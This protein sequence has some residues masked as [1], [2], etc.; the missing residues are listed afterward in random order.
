MFVSLSTMYGLPY[1]VKHS[2]STVTEVPPMLL[3]PK[4]NWMSPA[5]SMFF[6]W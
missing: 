3:A 1:G 4:D 5:A 6:V 2:V